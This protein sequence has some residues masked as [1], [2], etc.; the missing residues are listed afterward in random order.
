MHLED[1]VIGEDFKLDERVL[2]IEGGQVEAAF[3]FRRVL[4]LPVDDV[5]GDFV[6]RRVND[7]LL[8]CAV[9]EV[10]L[11]QFSE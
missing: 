3:L 5:P 1:G 10:F 2:A 6:E 7:L 4:N 9:A 11:F 8:R